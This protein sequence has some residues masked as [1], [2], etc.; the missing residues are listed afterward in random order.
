MIPVSI[1]YLNAFFAYGHDLA[2]SNKLD[3][4][5]RYKLRLHH[6]ER[7]L[8]HAFSKLFHRKH[9]HDSDIFALHSQGERTLAAA[10]TAAADHYLLAGLCLACV[11]VYY[12]C[13]V[14]TIYARNGRRYELGTCGYEQSIRLLCKHL[15]RR[16]KGIQANIGA[17]FHSRANHPFLIP[18]HI[19]LEGQLVN[20]GQVSSERSR[21]FEKHDL[22]ASLG[23]DLS[24]R[25]ARNAAANDNDILGFERRKYILI[26]ARSSHL[27][28]DGT[29]YVVG[30]AGTVPTTQARAHLVRLSPVSFLY[31]FRIGKICPCHGDDIG[32]AFPDNFVR[33]LH[34]RNTS[35]RSDRYMYIRAVL[36][37]FGILYEKVVRREIRR[38]GSVHGQ[39]LD[40]PAA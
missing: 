37:C 17:T 21:R 5:F 34:G 4:V 12:I 30:R 24:G 1:L 29:A 38:H 32:L 22:V 3:V 15:F 2:V 25:H 14:R 20:V 18:A 31:D 8:R 23:T 16:S 10:G 27:R 7:D 9:V 11:G 6:P 39:G 13:H 36:D 40:D 35:H 33:F 26:V 28:I 19:S